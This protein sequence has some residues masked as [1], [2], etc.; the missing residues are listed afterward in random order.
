MAKHAPRQ[1]ALG[2]AIRRMRDDAGLTQ[3]DLANEA[4]MAVESLSRIEGGANPTWSTVKN[5]AKALG[6]TVTA[7]AEASEELE[8]RKR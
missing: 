2:R 8:T 3:Q 4:D 6:T 1:V 5:V 7:I